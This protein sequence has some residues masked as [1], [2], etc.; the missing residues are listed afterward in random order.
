MRQMFAFVAASVVAFG[1]AP[2]GAQIAPN[3]KVD[4]VFAR[5]ARSG[6]PG[7]ALGIV[8]NGALAYQ[9]GYGFASIE[10]EVPISPDTVFDIGSVSKQFTAMAILLLERDGKLS[11]EDDVRKYLPEIPDYGSRITIRHLLS[12]TSGL[13]DY[14]DLLEL[15]GHDVRDHTTDGDA[16]DIIVRQRGV[17]FAPGDEWRYSNTGFFLASMIV[18][19]VSGWPLSEFARERI[20]GP[21]GM[22]SSQY[23]D[24]TRRIVPHRAEA[25]DHQGDGSADAGFSIDMSDWD[26]TGDGAVQTT[27]TDMARWASNYDNPIVGDRAIV[28]AMQ[29]AGH[30]NSGKPHGYG[31]GLRIDSYRGVRRVAHG[32]SWAGYRAALSRFPDERTA[33]IVLCNVD[34]A[35]TGRLVDGVADASLQGLGP[36]ATEPARPSEPSP[37]FA[38]TPAQLREYAGRYATSE[39]TMPWDV[40]AI[41]GTAMIRVRKGDGDKLKPIRVDV[42]DFGGTAIEFL[43]DTKTRAVTSLKITNRGVSG[44]VLHKEPRNGRPS[45]HSR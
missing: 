14:N 1:F 28:E 25:Y 4:A 22:A 20:F 15:D 7:C 23:L 9:R 36:L 8:R 31:L 19:R 29:T 27:V 33:I 11:L 38:P 34:D 24:D 40:S 10:H 21:L 13:R 35:A 5:F 44:L 2:S 41:D 12:H 18:K 17:N 6:S 26:Q 3:A 45:D 32:G 37:T 42:F 30:L 39:L 43:R 16:L